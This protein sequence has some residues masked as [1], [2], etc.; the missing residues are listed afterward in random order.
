MCFLFCQCKRKAQKT[1]TKKLPFLLKMKKHLSFHFNFDFNLPLPYVFPFVFSFCYSF[2]RLVIAKV[3]RR[4]WLWHHNQAW[5]TT[6][7]H[8]SSCIA[9]SC[10]FRYSSCHGIIWWS[11]CSQNKKMMGIKRTFDLVRSRFFLATHGIDVGKKNKTCN[12]CIWKKHSQ[13]KLHHCPIS[14]PVGTLSCS[15]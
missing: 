4:L 11:H 15:V 6:P 9:S 13:S 2:Y 14:R 7:D 10:W 8:F 1:M 3:I 12:C 5:L